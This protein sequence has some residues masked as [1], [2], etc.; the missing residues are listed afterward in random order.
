MSENYA[1]LEQKNFLKKT[2][3]KSGGPENSAEKSG[4]HGRIILLQVRI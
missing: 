1:R 2:P 4:Q 3:E